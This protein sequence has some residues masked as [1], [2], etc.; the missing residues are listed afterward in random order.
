MTRW[1]LPRWTLAVGFLLGAGCGGESAGGPPLAKLQTSVADGQ[2]HT[3]QTYCT[4]LPVLLG[5]R[6]RAEIDV[7]GEFSMLLEGNHDLV[8]L[9]FDGV[10]D[11]AELEFVI[12]AETLRSA[13]TER[14]EVTTLRDRPFVV[15]L[16]SGC[17]P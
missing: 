6:V 13:Y 10:H 7:A 1:R 8:L 12:D 4:V 17:P 2:G 11:A 3:T 16:A 15:H 14:L 9:T 5:G